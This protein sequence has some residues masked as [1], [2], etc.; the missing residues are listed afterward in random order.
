[1]RALLALFGILLLAPASASLRNTYRISLATGELDGKPVLGMSL[2]EVTATLGK[3]DFRS[4]P[5]SRYRIGWG[6]PD[7]SR[8]SCSSDRSTAACARARSSSNAGRSETIVSGIC[9]REV[10]S[11]CRRRSSPVMQVS[12]SWFVSTSAARVVDS[13]PASSRPGMQSCMSRSVGRSAKARSS[14]SG[15]PRNKR[16]VLTPSAQRR[17]VATRRPARLG[18]DW[19]P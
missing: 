19:V 16:S 9:S 6:R 12:S 18:L 1:M 2:R 17:V 4:G 10:Q 5:R 15:S 11:P 7:T 8:S 13:A 3:P 14:R